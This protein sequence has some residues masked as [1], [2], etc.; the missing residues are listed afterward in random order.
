MN[1]QLIFTMKSWAAGIDEIHAKARS[2][3]PSHTSYDDRNE[4]IKHIETVVFDVKNDADLREKVGALLPSYLTLSRIKRERSKI[5]NA[6]RGGTYSIV[7][8][9]DS[10]T[11]RVGYVSTTPIRDYFVQLR[12]PDGRWTNVQQ[13]FPTMDGAKVELKYM[14]SRFPSESFR[15][16]W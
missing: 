4:R 12:Q 14:R 13:S 8:G 1:Y 11:E 6:H 10:P 5:K 9:G 16:G 2:E 7:F 3:S 15:I